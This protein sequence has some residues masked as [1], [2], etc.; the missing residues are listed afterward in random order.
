MNVSIKKNEESGEHYIDFFKDLKHMFEDPSK[1]AYYS[2][3]FL[4]DNKIA[5]EFFDENKEKVYPKQN[6]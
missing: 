2:I 1:V 3:E 6:D 4:E 5:L